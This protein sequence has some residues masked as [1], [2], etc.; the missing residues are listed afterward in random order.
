MCMNKIESLKELIHTCVE[1]G[2]IRGQ[3]ALMP[4][5]DRIRK[6]DAEN[7]LV[8]NG[9]QK[10]LLQRWVAQGLVDENRGERNSPTWYSL[11]QIME[12]IGAIRY[13]RCAL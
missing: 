6:K 13:E 2:Y 10:V 5:S 3:V 4:S 7:L 8:R 12:T 1:L 9:L 11:T